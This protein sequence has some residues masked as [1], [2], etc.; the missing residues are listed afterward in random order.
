MS[1]L[2]RQYRPQTFAEVV[3]QN[4]VKITLAEE[5]KRHQIASAYLFCGPRAVGKT[6]IA[7]LL[8]KSLNCLNRSED[9]AEPCNSCANCLTIAAGQSLDIIE[10]DAASQTGVDNVRENIIA[11]S[12]LAPSQGKYKVFIIDE[13]HMLSTSSFNALLKTLEEPPE[14]VI[15]ILCTT[16]VHKIPATVVSRCERFDFKKISLADIIK[17]LSYILKQ[18]GWSADETVLGAIAKNSQGHLRDAESLLG[19]LMAVSQPMKNGEL[20]LTMEDFYLLA[21]SSDLVIIS[22]F[23]KTLSEQNSVEAI[24]I[25]NQLV[26]D[27]RDIRV[28]LQDLIET[29]RQLLL[30][31]INPQLLVEYQGQWG[32]DDMFGLLELRQKLTI[33]QLVQFLRLFIQAFNETREAFIIQLPVEL[34]I[35][36]AIGVNELERVAKIDQPVSP[37]DHS[38]SSPKKPVKEAEKKDEPTEKDKAKEKK[39]EVATPLLSEELLE[40]WSLVVS[41]IKNHNFGLSVVLK[42]CLPQIDG[43]Q[44]C[45]VFGY[46]LH[47][48]Q[49]KQPSVQHLIEDI[50]AKVYGRPLTVTTRLLAKS[51][52]TESISPEN[53]ANNT[54]EGASL[55]N[56]LEIFNGQIVS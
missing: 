1:T 40:R 28:F 31:K 15:F 51:K 50:M 49:I 11:S 43:D 27:G 19:Q 20:H 38:S 12:R 21:P 5:I 7:R 47:Q 55:D 35:V 56:L 44:V 18:E 17:K 29:L 14:Q 46:K 30:S 13:V 23:I 10:V 42:D 24:T 53:K 6:T 4:H 41:E 16:E 26:A 33:N 45:L 22:Q 9:T 25:I 34:A 39:D 2:Y 36:R 3:G 52:S 48:D 37:S 32:E 8:A 54:E